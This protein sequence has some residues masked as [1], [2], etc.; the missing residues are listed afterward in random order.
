[1]S[2]VW[3]ALF[4]DTNHPITSPF[5]PSPT[6]TTPTRPSTLVSPQATPTHHHPLTDNS[7]VV[8]HTPHTPSSHTITPSTP[9]YGGSNLTS[10]TNTSSSNAPTV[11]NAHSPVQFIAGANRTEGAGMRSPKVGPPP[12]MGFVPRNSS[13]V[14]SSPVHSALKSNDFIR[15]SPVPSYQS[16]SH[17]ARF[18]S[19]HP[20]L[21]GGSAVHPTNDHALTLSTLHYMP[22]S[23]DAHT[24]PSPHTLT[25]STPHYMPMAPNRSQQN[26]TATRQ[27]HSS[28][29][30]DTLTN[31]PLNSQSPYHQNHPGTVKSG[32]YDFTRHRSSTVGSSTECM[33]PPSCRSRSNTSACGESSFGRSLKTR[34][35]SEGGTDAVH[36]DH[37]N[38]TLSGGVFDKVEPVSSHESLTGMEFDH[39][40]SE[41]SLIA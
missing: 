5:V 14:Q 8:E 3:K 7:V 39:L 2:S 4:G 11:T 6:Q 10:P 30:S 16:P 23:N 41:P 20:S 12:K 25:L 38:G 21:N 35:L 13:Y 28:T 29:T 33:E 17:S 32:A 22:T 40:R 1:M 37:R 19:P 9:I 26:T 36:Y 18:N 27:N 24:T 15:Q 31:V 34:A